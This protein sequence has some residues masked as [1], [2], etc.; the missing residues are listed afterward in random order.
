MFQR[1]VAQTVFFSALLGGAGAFLS[2]C[3]FSG[4]G[5]SAS[6]SVPVNVVPSGHT[7]GKVIGGQNPVV[8]AVIQVYQI[9]QGSGSS[10]A[11]NATPLIGTTV[12]SGAGGSFDITGLYS[13]TPGS[14]LYLTAS[15]GDPGLGTGNNAN[16]TMMTSLGLCENAPNYGFISVNEVTTVAMAY[17]FAQFGRN[18]LFGTALSQ[19]SA[20]AATPAINFATSSTNMQ[21]IAT[22]AATFNILVNGNDGTSPGSNGNGNRNTPLTIS[23]ITNTGANGA[24]AEFWQINTIANILAAC[25]NSAGLS[26]SSDTTS[27][28]G[29]LFNQVTPY[30]GNLPADTAQAALD[31]ALYPALSSTAI[32][33]L[34][35]RIT[36]TP[37]FLPYVTSVAGI[38][39]FSVGY[40][41]KPTIPGT[42]TELLYMPTWLGIDGNGNIW[43]T[44]QTTSGTYPASVFEVNNVGVPIRAGQN[45]GS[46]TANYL[47]STYGMGG[48]SGSSGVSTALAGQYIKSTTGTYSALGKL[49]GA[50][51]TNNNLWFGDRGN[52]SVVK[53]PGSGTNGSQAAYNGGNYADSGGNEAVGYQLPNGV[54]PYTTYA[55][56]SYTFIDGSNN[57]WET[58]APYGAAGQESGSS[59]SC[60]ATTATTLSTLNYN[61]GMIGFP[62]GVTTGNLYV[63]GTYYSQT[64]TTIA[65]DPNVTD[66]TSTGGTTTGIPG[67]PFLWT[68]AGNL[69]YHQYSSAGAASTVKP[70]CASAVNSV[71]SPAAGT[72]QLAGQ[73]IAPSDVVYPLGSNTNDIGFDSTGNLWIARGGNLDPNATTPQVPGALVKVMPNYGT[74]FTSA[75]MVANTTFNYFYTAGMTSTYKPQS[76]TVDG[77]GN[78]WFYF[79]SSHGMGEISNS[80]AALS[81]VPAGA[82]PGFKGSICTSCSFRG[83]SAITYQRSTNSYG[84][85]K[86]TIDR[87]G[88]LFTFG[89]GTGV[90]FIQVLVGVAGPT[91]Q[92]MS[93]A[94]QQGKIGM[95]P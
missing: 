58:I 81:P 80:G 20:S 64:P 38:N 34:Y 59:G 92:P 73:T 26:S 45:A 46:A 27:S 43:I 16:S 1:G 30:G 41:F 47:I 61:A 11:G 10:Y 67:A 82:E 29:V 74:A 71:G 14:Y 23:G 17:A 86:P 65:M 12:K 15:G 85:L 53:V 56:P 94:I 69:L 8:G 62:G 83:G 77:D 66:T 18:S 37:P 87:A 4:S 31:L 5:A 72:T 7:S 3:A 24:I 63:T 60:T 51:D 2:G 79:L 42:S 40:Q 54:S 19:Q 89:A 6:S 48:G 90:A 93:Q 39:D 95:R 57:V 35:G 36:G 78:V 68:T 9:G 88:N 21:G 28:C 52:Y 76:V 50:I 25:V 75:Q 22:A 84:G 91:M 44:Q 49:T 55:A 13:C 70:G 33:A 32:S